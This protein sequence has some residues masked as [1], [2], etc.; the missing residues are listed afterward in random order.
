M[1]D[2]SAAAV[3]AR[4]GRRPEEVVLD[5]LLERDGTA[6]LFAPLNYASGDHE[7]I[8]EMMEHPQ[9]VLGLSDGGAHCGVVRD[10]SMSTFLLTHWARDR[11]RGPRLPLERVVRMQT[12]EPA[13]TYGFA[14]RGTLE[15]GK[16]ADLNLVDFDALRL[17][18]PQMAFDLPGGGKRL[19]QKVDGYRA[20][21]VRGEVTFVDGEPTGARPGGLL[22]S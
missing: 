13:A 19:V 22:R 1:P 9:T 15:P 18:A 5:W 3:A 14:D 6:L 12:A 7:V 21:M 4:E 2:A 10:A 20:T 11:R 17:H 8:R 16:R